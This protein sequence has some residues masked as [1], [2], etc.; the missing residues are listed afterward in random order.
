MRCFDLV[1]HV[2]GILTLDDHFW[3]N[4]NEQPE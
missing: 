4:Q 1:K 2:V 3:P